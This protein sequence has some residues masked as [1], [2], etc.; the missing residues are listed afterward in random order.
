MRELAC[1]QITKAA[2][3]DT[4]I[5]L[6]AHS[7]FI[8]APAIVKAEENVIVLGTVDG[9]AV[10][11]RSGNICATCFHPEISSDDSWLQYFLTHKALC[12]LKLP[13]SAYATVLPP[14]ALVA[15]W[16][17]PA[18]HYSSP[19]PLSVKRG[20]MV[21]QQGGVIMDVVTAAQA[22]VAESAG[23]VSVMALERIPADIK[24]DGGIAR[25][26]DPILIKEIMAATTLPVMAKARIGH[27]AEAQVIDSLD[28]DCID[29]SEVRVGVSVFVRARW[30]TRTQEGGEGGSSTC[31]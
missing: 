4:P 12:S 23:A 2:I 11:A 24:K 20:F 1:V 31:V 26:S 17:A 15:P 30:G 27:F 6:G 5:K 16:A 25:M 3:A 13:K 28:V 22:R 18:E 29:E 7:H 9:V 21:F 8:R 14:A 10:A 19:V